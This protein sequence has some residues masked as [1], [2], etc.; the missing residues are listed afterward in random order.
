MS[1]PRETCSARTPA[2][3]R[4]CDHYR[5]RAHREHRRSRA[6]PERQQP[7]RERADVGERREDDGDPE[8]V[9]HR[10]EPY[11]RWVDEGRPGQDEDEVRQCAGVVDAGPVDERVGGDGRRDGQHEE[12]GSRVAATLGAP[13]E[14]DAR[15]NQQHPADLAR[16]DR[17]PEDGDRDAEHDHRRQASCERVDE[18]EFGRPVGVGEREH[19]QRLE[20]RR[21]ERIWPHRRLG[22]PEDDDSG[23]TI[24]TERTNVAAVAAST[25]RARATSRFQVA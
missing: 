20:Q 21:G 16:G 25:S 17:V 4:R 13:D 23:A 8:L 1:R 6:V 12:E 15:G 3:E 11:Y 18:R 19:V 5:G 2:G 22:A 24:A 7:Q 10:A 9:T 14:H